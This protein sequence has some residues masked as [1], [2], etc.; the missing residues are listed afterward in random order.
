MKRKGVIR[1][2]VALALIAGLIVV[3]RLPGTAEFMTRENI[4]G[5]ME[6]LGALGVGFFL[7]VFVAGE[8]LYIPGLLFVFVAV[9][10]YGPVSGGVIAYVASVISVTVSF[11]IVRG[12]GGKAL[13]ELP[14]KFARKIMAGLDRRPVVTVIVLRIL[15]VLSPPL[16]YTLALSSIRF[17]DY[18]VGSAIG[19][20][21]PVAGFTV[22]IHFGMTEW[23]LQRLG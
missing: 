16:N 20:F 4:Q 19:L 18:L 13:A 22:L 10:V 6:S 3:G 2:I 7:L 1:L 17:R 9:F 11:L 12:V 8:L 21:F 5:T 15:L 14:F 23:L